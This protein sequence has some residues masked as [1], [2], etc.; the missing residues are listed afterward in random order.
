M[1]KS[2]EIGSTYTTRS[3]CNYDCIFSF[4]VMKRTAKFVTFEYLGKPRRVGVK[5][6]REG[7]EWC[8]PLGTYSMSPVLNA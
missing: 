3:F 8:S 7:N 4:K 5:V 1:T 2:F 6:D